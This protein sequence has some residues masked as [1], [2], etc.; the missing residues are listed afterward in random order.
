MVVG[1]LYRSCYDETFFLLVCLS[2]LCSDVC[3]LSRQVT[4]VCI[5]VKNVKYN[6]LMQIIQYSWENEHHT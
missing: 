4:L 1:Q 3:S 2:V 6:D 5:I